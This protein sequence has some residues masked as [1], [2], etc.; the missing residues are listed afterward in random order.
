VRRRSGTVDPAT[1][2]RCAAGPQAAC[3]W[4]PTS[5]RGTSPRVPRHIAGKAPR[6]RPGNSVAP[7]LSCAR[8]PNAVV[9]RTALIG[10][11][12]VPAIRPKRGAWI[13]SC[14]FP[15][16]SRA[17]RAAVLGSGATSKRGRCAG[18]SR[19]GRSRTRTW[20]LFLIRH[21]QCS[22]RLA[23]ASRFA[24]GMRNSGHGRSDS[25][26]RLRE[27]RVSLVRHPP[28]APA[29]AERKQ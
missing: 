4:P 28:A 16:C 25:L 19:S 20:D 6:A 1:H 10:R 11:P 21:L 18:T 17:S 7:Q 5:D 29:C 2:A 27:A 13:A 8:L 9:A 22:G 3:A 24:G 15:A 23:T 12:R 26:G 14:L